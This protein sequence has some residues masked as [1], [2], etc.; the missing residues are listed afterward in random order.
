MEPVKRQQKS[1][2]FFYLYLLHVQPDLSYP[3]PFVAGPFATGP[4]ATGPFEDGRC[5]ASN[6]PFLSKETP[7]AY[8]THRKRE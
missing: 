2:A 4:F 3:E 1:K 5:T 7:A 6:R 8:A